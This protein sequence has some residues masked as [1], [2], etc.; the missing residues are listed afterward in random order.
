MYRKI[1]EKLKNKNIAILG[2]G[3]EGKSTYNFIRRY[4]KEQKLTI[5]DKNP[6]ET[7]DPNIELVIGDN[8]LN[9]LDKYDLIIKSPGISLKD[10]DLS[11]IKDKITSQLELVLE[12]FKN[13]I[14][15]ITG[16]KGKS[17]TTLLTYEMI[18][19]QKEDVYLLGNIG[20]PLLD[21]VEKYNDNSTLV[22]EMSSHQLEFIKVSPHIAVILNLF[23]D[24]LDHAGSLEH[25]HDNKMNIFKYQ[26]KDDYAIYSEDNEYLRK[27]MEGYNY[28]AKKY[29]IRFDNENIRENSVRIKDKKVYLNNEVIYEDGKR[30]IIG[31]HNLKNIMFVMTIAKIL[32]LDLERASKKVKET[33]GL[34][35]RM[36][37]IGEFNGIKYY[38][39]TIATIPDA[40]ISA[41]KAIG[42]VNTLIFGGLDRGI[43]YQE[44]I[45]FLKTS[46]IENLV[47]MPTTGTI[48]GKELNN[49]NKSI[50]FVETLKEAY[51]L[52]KEKTKKGTSCLLSPA[53]ASYE[54]FKNFEEKGMY[55]EKY[56]TG[57]DI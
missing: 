43:D 52:A 19:D 23:Q 29:N 34:K 46:E 10:I 33:K 38:N 21:D 2:F 42:D 7:N 48:I 57:K 1:I 49:T 56:V 31:D 18:K 5:I 17:T 12:V 36:E 24:H 15:G 35:Y 4:L 8:Y 53:A 9:N 22:I 55:F 28:Q 25:Y 26:T 14:I 47:C 37:Y 45:E 6:V 13:N 39:D 20:I 32:N 51:E 44:F 11:N 40:T 50:Y 30:L 27:R 54:Y 16:T 3:K 41:V